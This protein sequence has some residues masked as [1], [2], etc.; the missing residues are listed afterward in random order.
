MKSET[1]SSVDETASRRRVL[2]WVAFALGIGVLGWASMVRVSYAS[3][4]DQRVVRVFDTKGRPVP[5]VSIDGKWKQLG[6]TIQH[7]YLGETDENGELRLDGVAERVVW[8]TI[9]DLWVQPEVIGF[10]GAFR[11]VTGDVDLY[12]P[13]CGVIEI[14]LAKPDGEAWADPSLTHVGAQLS[15]QAYGLHNPRSGHRHAKF[16]ASGRVGF[17]PVA[18]GVTLDLQARAQGVE[19]RQRVRSSESA[20]GTAN[21][22]LTMPADAVTITGRVTGKNGDPSPGELSLSIDVDRGDGLER[23]MAAWTVV[24]DD[25]GRFRFVVESDFPTKGCA[26]IYDK[27]RRGRGEASFDG[28]A[29]GVIDLGAIPLNREPTAPR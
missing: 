14:G 2:K 23:R 3:T 25:E 17:G 28:V 22:T 10:T 18:C 1:S 29:D 24:A 6:V 12:L 16:D 4:L 21:F 27:R 13:N 8:S 9:G 20:G 11:R 26:R 7:R 15:W 19:F 5:G